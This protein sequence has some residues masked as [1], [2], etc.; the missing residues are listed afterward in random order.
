VT[1]RGRHYGIRQALKQAKAAGIPVEKV[2]GTMETTR[3]DVAT[4]QNWRPSEIVATLVDDLEA[5]EYVYG[6]RAR[7]KIE[8]LR[9]EKAVGVQA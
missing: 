6:K 1:A 3:R 8:Q 4:V 2:W 9:A 5:I 7:R